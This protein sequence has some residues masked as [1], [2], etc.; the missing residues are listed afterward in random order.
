M[1]EASDQGR[2]VEAAIDAV[3][4]L[5]QVAMAIFGEVDVVVGPAD[6]RLEI[7]DEGVDPAKRLQIARL[8]RADDDRAVLGNDGAGRGEA[9]EAVGDQVH[10]GMQGAL[11]PCGQRRPLEVIDGVEAYVP[12]MASVLS[13]TAAMNGDLFCEPRPGLPA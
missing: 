2:Q 5:G 6:R 10:V 8:A 9:S 1:N 3:L 12:R 11:S 7:G 4:C 13:S